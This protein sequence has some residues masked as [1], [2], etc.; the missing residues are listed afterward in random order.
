LDS[1]AVDGASVVV[2]FIVLAM[3]ATCSLDVED[4]KKKRE[5]AE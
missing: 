2:V 4:S 5:Y 3:K 1:I